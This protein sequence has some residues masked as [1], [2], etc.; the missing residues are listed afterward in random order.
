[1]FN[2]KYPRTWREQ[3]LEFKFMFAYHAAMMVM[4][5][6]GMVPVPAELAIAGGAIL[7][8]AAMS[9]YRRRRLAWRHPPLGFR[10]IA[11]AIGGLAF[12]VLFGTVAAQ[13]FPVFDPHFLPWL[14]ALVGIALFGTLQQLKYVALSEQ[15]FLEMGNPATAPAVELPVEAGGEPGWHRVVRGVHRAATFAAALV[16]LAFMYLD[17]K[18][19]QEGASH[20]TATQTVARTEHGWTVY[21]ARDRATLLNELEIAM[22]VAIPS[23]LVLGFALQ[24]AGFNIFPGGIRFFGKRVS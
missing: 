7:V 23:V 15:E 6:P 20:P 12:S 3:S 5:V 22:F 14:L 24:L 10:D 11:G 17:G 9:L 13:N 19:M 21:L 8:F 1:M 4:F 16:F 2:T 18:A